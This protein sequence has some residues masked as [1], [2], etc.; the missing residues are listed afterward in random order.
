MSA[1]NAAQA[2]RD[3]IAKKPSAINKKDTRTQAETKA[4]DQLKYNEQF[5]SIML[6]LVGYE[7]ENGRRRMDEDLAIELTALTQAQF[8]KRVS[9]FIQFFT[10]LLKLVERVRSATKSLGSDD[11]LIKKHGGQTYFIS[12]GFDT[13]L[14]KTIHFFLGIATKLITFNRKALRAPRPRNQYRYALTEEGAEI[15]RTI[16]AYTKVDAVINEVDAL[17]Q[18]NNAPYFVWVT[19][20]RNLFTYQEVKTYRQILGSQVIKQL[21]NVYDFSEKPAKNGERRVIIA[22]GMAAAKGKL[23]EENLRL[24]D[25]LT[26]DGVKKKN[27]KNSVNNKLVAET[28]T[29]EVHSKPRAVE[30]KSKLVIKNEESRDAI[31]IRDYIRRRTAIKNK[32][33]SDQKAGN[34]EIVGEYEDAEDNKS[35]LVVRGAKARN[36]KLDQAIAKNSVDEEKKAEISLASSIVSA[37]GSGDPGDKQVLDDDD[38]AANKESLD[39]IR[40]SLATENQSLFIKRFIQDLIKKQASKA[41]SEVQAPSV[42]KKRAAR[43]RK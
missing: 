8:N 37:M 6:G 16:A 22:K 24:L 14:I 39:L 34:D 35:N 3:N 26:E 21:T 23:V 10:N 5:A 32:L 38:V 15:L 20:V 28:L 33:L 12:K 13:Q 27:F 29:L 43:A 42:T 40:E 25:K 2:I 1:S 18:R 4:N 9:G 36:V 31:T 7:D 30:E 41:K 17:V 11:V 19:V